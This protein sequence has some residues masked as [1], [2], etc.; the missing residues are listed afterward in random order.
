MK[1][2]VHSTC[3]QIR[4]IVFECFREIEVDDNIKQHFQNNLVCVFLFE[5]RLIM[6]KTLKRAIDNTS[7]PE[8]LTLKIEN[9]LLQK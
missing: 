4:N 1:N 8:D 3:E 9:K 2:C 7:V 6:K 5:E